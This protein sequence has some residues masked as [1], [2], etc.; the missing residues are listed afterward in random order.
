MGNGRVIAL[1][2]VAAALLATGVAQADRKPTPKERKA[3]AKI[4]Q[5]PETCAHIRV[6]TVPGQPTFATGAYRFKSPDKCDKYA[7]DGV[8]IVKKTKRGWRFV[9]AG[10]D[11]FCKDL[12][13]NVPQA[14]VEDLDVFCS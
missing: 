12:Y 2:G 6:S 10:S 13:E 7:A 14:V 9:D 4:L 11:F 3:V 1:A 5:I 8:V